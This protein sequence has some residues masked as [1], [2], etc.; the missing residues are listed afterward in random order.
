MDSKKISGLEE[1]DFG[2]NW[3]LTSG[4]GF[5]V[6]LKFIHQYPSSGDMPGH[7]GSAEDRTLSSAQHE[8]P[9]KQKL[10]PSAQGGQTNTQQLVAS[11]IVEC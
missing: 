7:T 2:D 10:S 1:L 4:T 3:V 11:F 9:V 8:A 5:I 6:F